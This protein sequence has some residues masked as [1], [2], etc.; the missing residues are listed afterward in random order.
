[1]VNLLR[2]R[3]IISITP[4][5]NNTLLFVAANSI[6]L[7]ET[8][9]LGK[10]RILQ[11]PTEQT[12]LYCRTAVK[13][14][15]KLSVCKFASPPLP[16]S[17][18]ERLRSSGEVLGPVIAMMPYLAFC[19]DQDLSMRLSGL[20]KSEAIGHLSLTENLMRLG[21]IKNTVRASSNM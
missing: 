16:P 6:L 1:M 3:R 5:C 15:N 2:A 18:K 7:E 11:N 19:R 20:V 17:L 21:L 14:L 9:I 4:P 10:H 13:L 12:S 8:N